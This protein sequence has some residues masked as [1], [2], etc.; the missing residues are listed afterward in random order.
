MKALGSKRVLVCMAVVL[1]A[2][3]LVVWTSPL[4]AADA[5]AG[6]AIFK[7][8]CVVCHGATGA[9]EGP[10]GKMLRPP[11]PDLSDAN[12]MSHESD[13]HLTKI[14][15]EGKNKMPAYGDK[16]SASEIQDVLAYIRTLAK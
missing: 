16:L 9:G 8:R 11:P 6:G 1:S 7:K 2:L 12:R 10:M 3:A 14:I 5:D 15:T 13:E 4:S